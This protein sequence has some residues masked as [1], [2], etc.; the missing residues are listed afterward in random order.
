MTEDEM[1]GWHHQLDGH[2]FEQAPR[3]GML[4]YFNVLKFQQ[5][6]FLAAGT[7]LFRQAFSFLKLQWS[8][9][10]RKMFSSNGDNDENAIINSPAHRQGSPGLFLKCFEKRNINE[11]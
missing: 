9:E 6:N 10:C 8:C 1:V 11:C 2:E 5:L 3:V 4:K 7:Y